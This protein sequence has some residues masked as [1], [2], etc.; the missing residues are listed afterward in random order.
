VNRIPASHYLVEMD[1]PH[2]F[3]AEYA[4][5]LL[6][7]SSTFFNAYLHVESDPGAMGRLIMMNS[8]AGGATDALTIDVHVPFAAALGD[9]P[10]IEYYHPKLNHFFM[11]IDSGEIPFLVNDGWLA[12]GHSFKGWR[13]PPA[14][15]NFAAAPVCRFYGGYT[16][17]PNSHFY[18][19]EPDECTGLQR[20]ETHWTLE[21]VDFYI[22]RVTRDAFGLTCPFGYIGVNRAYNNGFPRNDSNHRYTTSDSTWREMGRMGWALEGTVMCSLP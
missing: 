20:P 9:A 16:G 8:I 12:T 2:E 6:T 1:I 5:E 22:K 17:G 4:G 13:L 3:R 21:S 19:A 18:T 7:W 15:P 14:N 10:V 11:T